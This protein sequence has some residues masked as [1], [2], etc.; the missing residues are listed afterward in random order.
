LKQSV[1]K[2]SSQLLIHHRN[3]PI[4]FWIRSGYRYN[5]PCGFIRFKFSPGF[6]RGKNDTPSRI[7]AN[8]FNRFFRF[9]KTDHFLNINFSITG[10]NKKNIHIGGEKHSRVSLKRLKPFN[11]YWG[12]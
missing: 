2:I 8:G 3:I 6:I 7:S 12:N 4:L 5:S 9:P 11:V 1:L 10:F